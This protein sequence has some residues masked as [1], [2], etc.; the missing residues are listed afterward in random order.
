MLDL[1]WSSNPK[2]MLDK[3]RHTLTSLSNHC[4]FQTI[5]YA[6][7][8]RIFLCSGSLNCPPSVPSAS[9]PTSVHKLRPVDVDVVAAI[10]D[11]LTAANGALAATPLGLLT[12][13]RYSELLCF[14]Y[15][16]SELHSFAPLIA[17]LH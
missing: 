8:I 16:Y 14:E 17:Q 13:Y 3:S 9:K 2:C 5:P 4:K 10:G 15:R 1:A 11:S 7:N 6:N 12:E